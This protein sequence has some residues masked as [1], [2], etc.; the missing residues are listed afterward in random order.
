MSICAGISVPAM[1]PAPRR[2][3]TPLTANSVDSCTRVRRRRLPQTLR[4]RPNRRRLRRPVPLA[5]ERHTLYNGDR[6][7]R[8]IPVPIL[9]IRSIERVCQQIDDDNR[10]PINSETISIRSHID[11][12]KLSILFC[13]FLKTT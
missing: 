7:V 13:G 11:F 3:D 9:L 8:F 12:F 10:R 6:I 4:P 5:A 2:A 1:W